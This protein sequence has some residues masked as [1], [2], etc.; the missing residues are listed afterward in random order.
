ML[1]LLAFPHLDISAPAWVAVDVDGWGPGVER[2]VN[3]GVVVRPQ[4][5]P[6]DVAHVLHQTHVEGRC[7]R[8]RS[9]EAC[10][11]LAA[12]LRGQA[13]HVLHPVDGVGPPVV[14]RD[15]DAFD[16][17][18]LARRKLESDLVYF[19]ALDQI[20]KP[21]VHAEGMIAELE[22]RA[23]RAGRAGVRAAR[24]AHARVMVWRR[25]RRRQW[26][27]D[28]SGHTRDAATLLVA[29]A[30]ARMEPARPATAVVRPALALR[31]ALAHGTALALTGCDA[32]L[33]VVAKSKHHV[34]HTDQRHGDRL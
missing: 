19:D 9:C 28:R 21:L 29:R 15:P 6:D 8:D 17:L 18:G 5:S 33:E 27:H 31:F 7:E 26:W 12:V 22:R 24:H 2:V 14:R 30:D 4:L 20:V 25:S 3:L 34:V 11:A 13:L 1:C 10:R 16:R 32:R 23:V